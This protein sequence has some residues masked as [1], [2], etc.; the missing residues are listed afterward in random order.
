MIVLSIRTSR[1]PGSLQN[2][3][4]VCNFY[5]RTQ[6]PKKKKNIIKVNISADLFASLI[7]FPSRDSP[8]SKWRVIAADSADWHTELSLSSFKRMSFHT[9]SVPED[10]LICSRECP[11]CRGAVSALMRS[12]FWSPDTTFASSQQ[13]LLHLLLSSDA[14]VL[15]SRPFYQ[16]YTNSTY[17]LSLNRPPLPLAAA[18]PP[19]IH[20]SLSL[21]FCCVS[22]PTG[23]T[24]S[25]LLYP[26]FYILPF[27]PSPLCASPAAFIVIVLLSYYPLEMLFFFCLFNSLTLWNL[28]H[29]P[30]VAIN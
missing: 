18:Y 19:S 5:F 24:H 20:A 21:F 11:L 8:F 30:R 4:H 2:Y 29:S 22:L 7:N 28:Q 14:S 15:L 3:L 1:K 17:C 23:K 12:L 13:L 26:F 6:H 25:F 10:A 27:F 16:S 9:A